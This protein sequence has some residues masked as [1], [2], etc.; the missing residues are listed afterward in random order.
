MSLLKLGKDNWAR[1]SPTREGVTFIGLSLFVGFAAINTGNNLLYL[2]FGTMMSFVV[3]SGIISMAN[4]SRIEVNLLPPRDAFALTPAPLKFSLSNRKFLIPSY[5]LTVEIEGK[6][7]YIPYLPTGTVKT[8]TVRY[9]FRERGWNRIPEARLSTRFPFGFFKKWI[10]VDIGDDEILV[11][12]KIDDAVA[13]A[14]TREDRS[15]EREPEKTGFGDDLRS[16]KEYSEG[17]NPRLIHWKTTAKTGRLM[18]REMQGDDEM[19]G[20]VIEFTPDSDKNRLEHQ[21][22]GIAALLVD[23]LGKGVRVEFIAPDR[24]FSPSQIGGSP[25]PVLTYL[26]LFDR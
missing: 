15:G 8:A 19:T 16:I 23:L 5:S 24:K 3:A 13:G 10:K 14:E 9:L 20:A 12:P 6:K 2:T 18:V 25:R 17:D 1:T 22:S 26:A 4:L 7:G 11:F 21:I